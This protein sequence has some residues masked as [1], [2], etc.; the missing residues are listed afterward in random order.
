MWWCLSLAG[1]ND[2]DVCDSQC[3]VRV[4]LRGTPICDVDPLGGGATDISR[5][6]RRRSLYK[7]T[8]RLQFLLPLKEDAKNHETKDMRI[9]NVLQNKSENT[10]GSKTN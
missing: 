9:V 5:A 7:L 2:T 4:I 6:A 10:T 3:G 1:N 8:I